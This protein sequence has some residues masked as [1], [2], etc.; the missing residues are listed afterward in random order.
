[1]WEIT[2]TIG[3]FLVILLMAAL[4]GAFGTITLIVKLTRRT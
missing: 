1:M 4:M 2:L 3:T